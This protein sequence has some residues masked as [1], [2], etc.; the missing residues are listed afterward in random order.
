MGVICNSSCNCLSLFDLQGF[1]EDR[2]CGKTG[3]FQCADDPL[4]R[5]IVFLKLWK[6]S[7]PWA[8]LLSIH[9]I[10][11]EFVVVPWVAFGFW[12]TKPGASLSYF[13]TKFP[14]L[15]RMS[16]CFL[17]LVNPANHISQP[18]LN[19]WPQDVRLPLTLLNLAYLTTLLSYENMSS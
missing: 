17:S 13:V 12:E 8:F 3:I 18:M 10:L 5:L 15:I 16:F 6:P 4:P 19:L 11:L 2:L 7:V 14:R 9:L 1:G